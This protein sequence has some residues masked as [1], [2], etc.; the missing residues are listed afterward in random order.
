LC[1]PPPRQRPVFPCHLARHERT[2]ASW[3]GDWRDGSSMPGRHQTP[4]PTRAPASPGGNSLP[5]TGRGRGSRRS[6]TPSPSTPTAGSHTCTSRTRPAC[7]RSRPR[8]A[9][10]RSRR[11]SLRPMSC[12]RPVTA[13]AAD[14]QLCAQLDGVRP[15][16]TS[17]M[18]SVVM[19]LPTRCRMMSAATRSGAP[20]DVTSRRRSRPMSMDSP[21]RSIRPSV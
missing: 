5:A 21:R 2:F 4:S 6:V 17:A 16:T 10:T 14:R 11:R 3:G 18:S 20:G 19:V 1:G 8:A 12:G 13:D 15:I 9:S 7:R